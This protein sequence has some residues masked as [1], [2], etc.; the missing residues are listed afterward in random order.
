MRIG[1]E[2][3]DY[4]Y[5]VAFYERL[6]LLIGDLEKD[7]H[8]H[9]EAKETHGLPAL[10]VDAEPPELHCSILKRHGRAVLDRLL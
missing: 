7:D 1:D 9:C 2:N 6:G 10:Q 8:W 3:L 4:E 5:H